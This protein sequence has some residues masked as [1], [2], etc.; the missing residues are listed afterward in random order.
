MMAV[1]SRPQVAIRSPSGLNEYPQIA[2]APCHRRRDA[3]FP[4]AGSAT[5]TSLRARVS[6]LEPSGV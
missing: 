3:S 5:S 4:V 1:W 6:S 2:Q